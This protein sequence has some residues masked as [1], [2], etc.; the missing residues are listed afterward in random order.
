VRETSLFWRV[1]LKDMNSLILSLLIFLA[2]CMPQSPVGRGSLADLSSGEDTTSEEIPT[3]VPVSETSW[4]FL[5]QN[6]RSITLNVSNLNNSYINGSSV[7][8]Y[9]GTLSGNTLVNFTGIDY[10]VVTDFTLGSS[11]L[12][13]RSRAVPISFFNFTEKRISRI[14]RV[15]FDN[16]TSASTV[17]NLDLYVLD[18]TENFVQETASPDFSPADLCPNC[19]RIINSVRVRLFKKESNVL[20][21]VSL[22]SINL[23]SLA[24]NVDPNFRSGGIAGTCS[25]SSCNSRGFDCCLD[26]Q[27]V[28]DGTPRPAALNLYSAQYEIAEE[29]KKLNP[30]AYINYPHI[31][32]VCGIEVPPV[33]SGATNG[34]TPI[35]VDYADGL[36][37]LK[38]DYLCVEHIKAQA[39]ADPFHLELLSR[40]YSSTTDCLT[41]SGDSGKEMYFQEVMKRMYKTCG[42]S[43]STLADMI[44]FC[45]AYEYT[46]TT[47]DSA[48]E[49]TKIDCYTPPSVEIVPNIQS[50]TL[51][52]RS[53]P[54]RFFESNNGL[55]KDILNGEKTFTLAGVTQNFTQEGDSFEYL[56]DSSLIP[57]QEDFGMNSIL[58]QMTVTLDKAL[59]AKIVNVNFDQVYIISTITGFYTPCPTCNKDSWINSFTAFPSTNYGVGLQAIG[60]TTERDGLS[61]NFT[62]GNYEDTIFGRACWIPPTM[63]PYSHDSKTTVKDQ[64]LNRLKTQAALFV[65][66][67]QRD[68]YGFNKGALIGS[69]D[70]VTWFAIGKGRIVKATS[71]RL[72]L[73]INA[74]FGDLASPTLQTVQVQD[75]DGITQAAQVDYDPTL[76]AHH[77]FQNEAG[78]CQAYHFCSTDT[79]C[80]TKLGWEY[81]CADVRDVKTLWPQFDANGNEKVGETTLTLDQILQQKKFPTVP[82]DI[83]AHATKRCVYRGAG[84]PCINNAGSVSN[85]TIRKN[86][87]CAPNF[88]CAKLSDASSFNS[89]I[90][91]YAANL[92]DIPITKNHLFGKDANVL[93]RPLNY[94]SVS[95][96]STL[97]SDI[98]GTLKENVKTF[99]ATQTSSNLGLC[100]PAKKLPS[101]AGISTFNTNPYEQHKTS[102]STKRADFIS[103]IGSCN[104]GLFHADRYTSC[105]ALDDDGNYEMFGTGWTTGNPSFTTSLAY[106]LTTRIQNA[107]G[108]DTL[109][110]SASTASSIDTLLNSSPFRNIESKPLSATGVTVIE[111]TFARDACFRR[112]GAVCHTDLDCFPN[113]LHADQVDSFPIS[114][115]GGSEA[116]QNFHREFLICGQADPKPSTTDTNFKDYKINQNRCC[117]EVGK[118]FTTYTANVANGSTFSGNISSDIDP[119]TKDLRTDYYP[120]VDLPNTSLRYSR[121]ATVEGLDGASR[122]FLT[123]ADFLRNGGSGTLNHGGDDITKT[124]QWATLNEANSETCCGGGWVRKFAD[125][126]NDWSIRNRFFL[127]VSGFACINSMTVLLTNPTKAA[128]EYTSSSQLESLLAGDRFNYCIDPN[129]QAGSCANFTISNSATE[130]APVSAPYPSTITINT[131]DPDFTTGDQ[132]DFYFAPK[133]ADSDGR[134]T[135]DY[136]SGATNVRKNITI[137]IPSYVTKDFNPTDTGDVNMINSDGVSYP[138]EKSTLS[139]LQN[140]TNPSADDDT[141]ALCAASTVFKCCYHYNPSTR[142]LKVARDKTVTANLVVD[143]EVGISFDA[144]VLPPTVAPRF[145]PGSSI[146]YLNRLDKLELNGIPQ[147]Y[148]EP[149]YC[150][151]DY[152]RV[153]PGIFKSSIQTRSNFTGSRSISFYSGDSG[154]DEKDIYYANNQQLEMDPIFSASEFKCCANLGKTVN[155]E[156]KCCSGYGQDV[157][158][159]GSS[160]KCMLPAGTDLMVYFNRFVSND[161]TDTEGPGGGLEEEDFDESTGK[162][163]FTTTVVDKIRAL[164]NEYCD[165]KGDKVRSGAAFG[166]FAPQPEGPNTQSA[167]LIFG[168]VDSSADIGSVSSAGSTFNVGYQAFMDGFRWNNH[169]YCNED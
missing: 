12:Q 139:G 141:P 62:N 88:Y 53:V 125:S 152:D 57:S 106:T 51:S 75:Y 45:P 30:L 169:L 56:D 105:P 40:S 95:S 26:N 79:D 68:W 99:E 127:D 59:P 11:K 135:A 136:T 123:A 159:D 55:E 65:N 149:L 154:E 66:G 145:K 163:L 46:V 131:I 130:T 80:I 129:G 156:E 38:K 50:V 37:L 25:N 19:T 6:T 2:A 42:C 138:C 121:F 76:T 167:S 24:L 63:I 14:L 100:Q 77:S 146:Y 33:L 96:G 16:V 41:A 114:F 104:A 87:T 102:D 147:I 115:F 143:E 113:K 133:S 166:D 44:S 103:Q 90:V 158:G 91:R 60:H 61:T 4:N 82:S 23:G 32:Y 54:H 64:R 9:L 140:L 119:A 7:E 109:D 137:V 27:C 84:A 93:G 157:N 71:N 85:M 161:G 124:K 3:D 101:K 111:P 116:E 97:T 8:T 49:P 34:S 43:K 36:A 142:I 1:G 155:Q 20:K 108:L 72:F 28:D 168:I 126:S 150:S 31:Y 73:A 89:K 78:N 160:F 39:T 18:E 52:S 98:S 165:S 110:T 107:C 164:G 69:F 15:D 47:T 151:D 118:D 74:P 128:G 48:G 58:G 29:E 10:C 132:V 22:A 122:P 17:C 148:Y 94:I 134:T 81:M 67:Y 35:Q 5:S 162:P 92:E 21:E 70:G 83:T 112:A 86:L 13:L 117:R 153:V 120:G 144:K